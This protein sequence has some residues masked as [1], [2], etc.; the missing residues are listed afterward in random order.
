MRTLQRSEDGAVIS[1]DFYHSVDISW[2]CARESREALCRKSRWSCFVSFMISGLCGS[3]LGFQLLVSL[4]GRSALRFLPLSMVVTESEIL[5][6]PRP[7][8]LESLPL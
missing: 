4:H 1:C 7:C 5:K 3:G 6:V 8:F 2:N